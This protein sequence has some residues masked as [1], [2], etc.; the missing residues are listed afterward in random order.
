MKSRI[1]IVGFIILGLVSLAAA[2]SGRRVKTVATPQPVED[3]TV[4]EPGYSESSPSRAIPVFARSGA[5]KSSKSNKKEEPKRE[6]V[7]VVETADG[8]TDDDIIT[9]ESALIT[10]PVAVYRRNGIYVSG[11]TKENFKVFEDGEEQEIEYFGVADKPFTVIMVIDMSSSTTYKIEEIQAAARA[12]VGQ[13]KPDDSVM[14]IMFDE[15]VSVLTDPTTDRNE[16]NKAINR[17]NFGG[18][19]SLYDAVATSLGKRL[20][21]IEG[22]KAI[23]LFTDGVDTTSRRASY[24]STLRDADEADAIVFPIYYNTFLNMRGIGGGAGPMTSIP[25]VGVPG[26][27]TQIPK[28]ARSEDYTLGRLYL[29]DLATLTG[30]RVYK[31]DSNAASLND[32]FEGIADELRT[33]YNIGYYPR[34]VGKNGERKQIRVRVDRPNLAIRARDSY[35][36]GSVK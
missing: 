5:R 17:T 13:L 24:E 25:S 32:A 34:E 10:V 14:V 1:V 19:T 33:Q 20:R 28:G 11:L 8:E 29:D 16:I 23:V 7:E 31:P 18:G 15:R 36:V 3:N 22:R 2:Q 35:I 26:M 9:V 27:G 21:R 4:N 12:F 6:E 30:G